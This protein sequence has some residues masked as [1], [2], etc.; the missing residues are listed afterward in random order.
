MSDS[1][2]QGVQLGFKDWLKGR[3][4][5]TR[6]LGLD[7]LRLSVNHTISMGYSSF[8]G[9]SL[10]QSLYATN[11]A[12]KLSNPLTLS[13]MLGAQNNLLNFSGEPLNY[14]LLIGGF[15]LDYRPS[16][17]ILFR[18]EFS[19]N[20]N[21]IWNEDIYSPRRIWPYDY[22]SPGEYLRENDAPTR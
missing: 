13:I 5:P 8:S 9:G 17:D 20:P 22:E 10:M 14:N 6:T 11:I 12:Y 19:R 3:S 18:M 16:K 7:P 21:R 4:S 1:F 2:A 15:A